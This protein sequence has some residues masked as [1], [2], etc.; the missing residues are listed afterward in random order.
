MPN[1]T[2]SY[3]DLLAFLVSLYYT[4]FRLITIEQVIALLE[5]A[6]VPY[7]RGGFVIDLPERQ[8]DYGQELD[9]TVVQQS[10]HHNK[11]H[12]AFGGKEHLT[13]FHMQTS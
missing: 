8:Q 13:D 7:E 12:L 4:D 1:T 2:Q 6:Q 5:Q 9:F 10:G 3:R 11:I